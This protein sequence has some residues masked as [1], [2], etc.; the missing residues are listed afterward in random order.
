M[1]MPKTQFQF[2]FLSEKKIHMH[3]D[4]QYNNNYYKSVKLQEKELKV[5]FWRGS[6]R[7]L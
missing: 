6:S 5:F 3:I 4:I 7:L 2:I 1:G